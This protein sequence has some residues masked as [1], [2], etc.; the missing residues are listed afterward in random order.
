MHSVSKLIA[1]AFIIPFLSGCGGKSSKVQDAN[2]IPVIDVSKKYPRKSFPIRDIADIKYV[3]LE[4]TDDVLL[5]NIARIIYVSDERIIAVNPSKGD[6]FVFDGDGKIVSHFNHRGQGD[7]EY[8]YL[9][10]VVYDEKAKEIYIYG[11]PRF[12]VFAEN[13]EYKRTLQRIEVARFRLYNFD[14]ET[15]LAYDEYGTEGGINK[16]FRTKPYLFLS[17]KDGGIV[18]ELNFT[19]PV[20]YSERLMFKVKD[21]NGKEQNA[22]MAIAF[23]NNWHDGHDFVIADLSSDTIFQL[24][25]DKKLSPLIARTPSV[26]RN[27]PRIFLTPVVKNNQFIWFTQV[28]VD[29]ERLRQ[30]KDFDERDLLY[31]FI[32]G[33]TYEGSFDYSDFP[34]K[35]GSTNNLDGIDMGKNMAVDM[36]DAFQILDYMQNDE[37]SGALKPIAEN[38]KE[39]DNPVLII[40]KFK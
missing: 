18:S 3:P 32:D 40:M 12:L 16:T 2:N 1:I 21:A 36:I 30:G 26:H 20:R 35:V 8:L 28:T 9:N 10:Q 25:R 13:G 22:T 14:D 38:L 17:K 37:L 6:V 4:T 39:D 5:E 29:F 11:S 15:L 19:L 24:T 27:N 33:E 7:K 23:T 34:A 31:S